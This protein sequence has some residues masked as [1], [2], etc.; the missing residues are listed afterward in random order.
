MAAAKRYPEELKARAVGMVRDLERE[1]GPG[2]GAI[3]RVAR[4]LGLNPETLR[5][6]VRHEEKAERP[7]GGR[8][9]E[10]ESDKDTR[11]ADMEREMREL[12][13]ANEILRL[14]A[15]FFAKEVDLQPPR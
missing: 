2:R 4:Q 11:I 14:A 1:L 9:V 7:S 6:W 12:R 8:V 15:A 5:H 10:S 13:R 3:A